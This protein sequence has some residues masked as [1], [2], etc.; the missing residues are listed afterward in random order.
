MRW[1]ANRLALELVFSITHIYCLLNIKVHR[2]PT[3]LLRVSPARA[4]NIVNEKALKAPFHTTSHFLCSAGFSSFLWLPWS[5]TKDPIWAHS[6]NSLTFV[7][8]L[9]ISKLLSPVTY[10]LFF[11]WFYL[12][13]AYNSAIRWLCQGSPLRLSF[14]F[15][16]DLGGAFKRQ[17]HHLTWL[18]W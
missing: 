14:Y 18:I 5:L 6:I 15:D 12:Q 11:L 13:R 9:L 4:E 2:L 16:R 3:Q 1:G 17:C 8:S 10:D 7:S